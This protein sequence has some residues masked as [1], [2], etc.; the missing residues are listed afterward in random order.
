MTSKEIASALG[1]TASTIN[2]HR[3]LIRQKLKLSGKSVN[4]QAFLNRNLL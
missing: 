3:N 4:L 1:C 2:N